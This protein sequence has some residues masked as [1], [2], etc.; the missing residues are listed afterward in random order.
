VVHFN[1]PISDSYQ[2]GEEMDTVVV[3][4]VCADWLAESSA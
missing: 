1:C 4:Y 3:P 2:V